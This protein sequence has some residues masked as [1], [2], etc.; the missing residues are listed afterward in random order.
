MFFIFEPI[1]MYANNVDDFWFDIYALIGP[2]ILLFIM[3][4]VALMLVFLGAYFVSKKFNRPCIYNFVLLF[5][6]FCFICSYIHSNFLAGFLP[7]LDGTALDWSDKTANIISVVVTLASAAIVIVSRIKFGFEKTSKYLS[8]VCLAVFGMLAVSLGTACLTTPMFETKD[9]L[10]LATNK[11]LYNVS[12][13]RNYFVFL[14]DA[15]DATNFNKIVSGNEEYK[16][17]LKDFSFFPDTLGGYAFTRDSVPF[18]FSG[19]WNENKKPFAEYSA[20]AYDNSTF[21]R[22]L[23]DGGYQKN[24]YEMELN[25]RSEK[26]FG[27]DNLISI[28]HEMAII[29]LL[30]QEARWAAFRSLPFPLK[31]FSR[32]DSLYFNATQ[33]RAGND[34]FPWF[35]LPFYNN[36]LNRQ[37]NV[38]DEKLFQYIHIEGGHVP[39]DIDKDLNYLPNKDGT[40]IEKLEATMKII[41][42]YLEYLKTNNAYDNATIVLMAD[43]GFVNEGTDRQNPILYIKGPNEHHE[44][45]LVSKK[46]VSYA[47]LCQAFTEL[48]DGR[49]STEVFSELPTDGRVRRYLLNPYLHEEHMEEYEQTGKAWD[50]TT[51]KPTGRSFDL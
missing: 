15:V 1:T 37:A 31:R 36:H 20:E 9:V 48:L 3:S 42:S 40:Y 14:V 24:L 35:E 10:A 30:A 18:I 39:F 29:P 38:I 8:C 4:F 21:F 28:S 45:M 23:S 27:F 12:R 43:H 41:A 19:E 32:I 16:T 2:I 17:A 51:F 49:P 25:W 34:S 50:T 33:N 7:S 44:Q 5:A 11:N 26:A 6:G 22:T 47:D 13:D 46:Q